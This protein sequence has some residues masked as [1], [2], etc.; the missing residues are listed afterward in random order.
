MPSLEDFTSLCCD[1][2][3][4]LIRALP[5]VKECVDVRMLWS[6]GHYDG[7][8]SGVCNYLRKEHWFTVLYDCHMARIYGIVEM[9]DEQLSEEK[10][11]HDLWLKY[12]GTNCDYT[13]VDGSRKRGE[14]ISDNRE[15]FDLYRAET[16]SWAYG[17]RDYST[18]RVVARW[19]S[20][21]FRWDK[22]LFDILRPDLE[23]KEGDD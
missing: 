19:M 5:V 23:V 20:G 2:R 3:T 21:Y 17:K 15:G 1:D 16:Q 14:A 7:P 8:W 12:M 4:S 6:T 18:G 22:T 13:Y 11:C 10:R 9:T